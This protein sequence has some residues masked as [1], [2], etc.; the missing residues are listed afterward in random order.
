MAGGFSVAGRHRV[1]CRCSALR[2]V[3]P[4][5]RKT[6]MGRKDKMCEGCR[7]KQASFGLPVDRKR[8]WCGACAKPAGAVD[9]HTNKMCV[10]S[11]GSMGETLD[12]RNG[13]ISVSDQPHP[14]CRCESCGNTSAN[15]GMPNERKRRWCSVCAKQHAGTASHRRCCR[16]AALTSAAPNRW[17]A[18]A[19][20]RAAA[21]F[22]LVPRSGRERR[23]QRAN[24]TGNG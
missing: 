24:S 15:F 3:K 12:G 13:R 4:L 19:V 6:T 14:S 5:P 21:S 2:S 20:D 18:G 23:S 16:S 8:R 9:L 10:I 17:R 1:S 7:A 11:P 22:S